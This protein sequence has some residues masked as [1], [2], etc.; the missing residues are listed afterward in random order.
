MSRQ[1]PVGVEFPAVIDAAHAAVLVAAIEQRRAAMR[2]AMVHDADA[3][4]AVAERDQ[5][6]AQQHQP[7]R[8]AAG[9]ELR[10]FRGGQP[11]LP[12]QLAHRRAGADAGQFLA[13]DRVGHVSLPL[14]LMTIDNNARSHRAARSTN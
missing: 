7:Q 14:R 12:H 2:A 5:L 8:I 13:F 9:D 3:P 1:L 4:G 10:R 6:L 11:I